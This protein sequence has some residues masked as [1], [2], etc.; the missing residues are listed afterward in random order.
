MIIKNKI[1]FFTIVS[2]FIFSCN[3]NKK[4][5]EI[6]F[7]KV[8]DLNKKIEIELPS[9]WHK[10]FNTTGFSSGII[11]SEMTGEILNTIVIN[12]NWNEDNVFV[13]SHLENIIDSL[14]KTVG[15]NTK[16]SKTGKMNNNRACFNF[17]NG[18]DT[19]TDLNRNQFL[20]ILN[21]DS[22][23]GHILFTATI[24]GDSI[25]ESQSELIAEI[26]KSIKMKK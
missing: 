21:S 7:I 9:N 11:A 18:F 25:Q 17:S 8:F 12:A 26:V 24:Y 19:L 13:N 6:D 2:G 20:Y 4:E 5:S 15:L 10:E 23:K 1:I 14:N 16:I 3:M 22:V